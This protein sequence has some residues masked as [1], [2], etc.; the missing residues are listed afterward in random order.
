MTNR[1][2]EPPVIRDM[3]RK[4]SESPSVTCVSPS[5]HQVVA[6]TSQVEAT[7]PRHHPSSA[8]VRTASGEHAPART[9]GTG[10]SRSTWMSGQGRG[11]RERRS[12]GMDAE[13]SRARRDCVARRGRLVSARL[14]PVRALTTTGEEEKPAAHCCA[15]GFSMKIRRRPTLPGSCPPS[16]IGASR[17]DFSVR[18][19][20]RYDPCAT[21][22]GNCQG[23]RGRILEV[24]P[25]NPHNGCCS[26]FQQNRHSH[27]HP[28]V[29]IISSSNE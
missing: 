27:A 10:T 5:T 13:R 1:F 3:R 22:T 12:R 24:E 8:P 16:T 2:R 4:W 6:A 20:K 25:S 9:R 14:A 26:L 11:A 17:L 7:H 23:D 29:F 18:N 15:T 28:K 19:G 21:T